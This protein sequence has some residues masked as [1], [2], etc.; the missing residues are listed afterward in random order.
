MA[1]DAAAN[2]FFDAPSPPPAA[3][4]D[5]GGRVLLF[6]KYVAPGAVPEARVAALVAWQKRICGALALTPSTIACRW[7][8]GCPG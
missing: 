1:E 8:T 4:T 3:S 2:Y 6:Y 7:S 5:G